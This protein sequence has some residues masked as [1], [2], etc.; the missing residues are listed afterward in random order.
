MIIGTKGLMF[1]LSFLD[2]LIAFKG[3]STLRTRNDLMA[4]F[5]SDSFLSPMLRITEEESQSRR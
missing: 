1:T 3:L 4:S 2:L 5:S